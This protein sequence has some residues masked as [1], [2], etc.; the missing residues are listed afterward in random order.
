MAKDLRLTAI[1]AV[2]DQ[3]SPVIQ[4]LSGKWKG[5]R[6]TLNSDNFKNLNK[7][8]GYFRRSLTNVSDQ[9][10]G[11]AKKLALPFTLAAG[12]VGFSLSQMMSNF[13]S[14]GDGIDKTSIRIGV[15]AERLQ[16][17]RYA[18]N[19]SGASADTLDKSMAKLNENM[20]KAAAGKNEEL[21][22]LFKKLG[23]SLKDA[24]GNLRNAADVM[25]QFADAIQRNTDA[26]LRARMMIAAFGEEGQKLVP[27]LEGGSGALQEMEDRAKR[28]GLVMSGDDVKAAAALGDR[29]SELGMV[30]DSFGNTLS[31]KIAPVLTPIIDDLVEFIAKNKEAFAGRVSQAV[32]QFAQAIKRIDFQAIADGCMKA[33]DAIGRVFDAIGGFETV[34]KAI[35]AILAGKVI[36]GLASFSGSLLTLGVSFAKLIPLVVKVGASFAGMLGPI[37]L[38]VAAVG[39]A[40]ALIIANWDSIGPKVKAVWGK[41]QEWAVEKLT[42]IKELWATVTQWIANKVQALKDVFS[43]AGELVAGVWDNLCDS[44]K[45]TWAGASDWISGKTQALQGVFSAAGELIAGIWSSVCSRIQELWEGFVG[46]FEG[47]IESVKGIFSG[48]IEFISNLLSGDLSKAF[49]G[50]TD[51]FT[52][53][54]DLLPESLKNVG[55]ALFS[56]A[57]SILSGIGRMF[58]DFFSK[59][60]L[61]ALMPDSLKSAFG[62]M[63]SKLGFGDGEGSAAPAMA[64]ASASGIPNRDVYSN[65]PVAATGGNMQGTMKIEVTATGGARANVAEATSSDNLKIDGNVGGSGRFGGD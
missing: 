39:T 33:F 34:L 24:N 45:T 23:I 32:A 28:L 47:K 60:D 46:E 43:A 40:A 8:F 58:T 37:G 31:A 7:Q 1:F 10:A 61:S 51:T 27:M 11:A 35:G 19:L 44:V 50:L 9:V 3:L 54:F 48:A 64:L 12:A 36:L 4:K 57:G 25:P 2:R 42:A 29:F 53:A 38:I 30:F 59:L 14:V 17:L 65:T 62:W 13:L 15:S 18:A 26:G 63:Q 20:A 56:Q 21:A 41:V 16:S 6:E 49:S 5:L 52:S 22:S 55:S